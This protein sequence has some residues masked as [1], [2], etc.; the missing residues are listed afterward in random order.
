[1]DKELKKFKL[2]LAK[3]GIKYLRAEILPISLTLRVLLTN[4]MTVTYT[5]IDGLY[6]TA[7]IPYTEETI[8]DKVKLRVKQGY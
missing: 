2:K 3:H 8:W 7:G 4:G 6:Y 5:C 1:M